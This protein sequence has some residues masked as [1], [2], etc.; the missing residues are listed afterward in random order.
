MRDGYVDKVTALAQHSQSF[1]ST[2][3]QN[4]ATYHFTLKPSRSEKAS[5]ASGNISTIKAF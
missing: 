4:V 3:N 2:L 5:P 1:F